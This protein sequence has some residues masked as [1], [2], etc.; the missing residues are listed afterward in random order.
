M[1]FDPEGFRDYETKKAVGDAVVSALETRKH[2]LR[3]SEVLGSYVEE[4]QHLYGEC[5]ALTLHDG[6]KFKLRIEQSE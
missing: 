3:R 6:R 4:I 5:I 2:T 1:V